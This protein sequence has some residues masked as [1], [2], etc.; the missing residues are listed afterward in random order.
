[1]TARR[2]SPRVLWYWLPAVLW[3]LAFR[4]AT[5]LALGGR[6]P[7]WAAGRDKLF[8]F[9]Y[10]GIMAFLFWRAFRFE[11]RFAPWTAAFAACLAA[12]VYGG[13][14]EFTQHFR[15]HRSA[16]F[17]DWLAD[18]AGASHVFLIAL[19]ETISRRGK[20][21]PVPEACPES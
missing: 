17:G 21:G 11:R 18:L 19:G 2:I 16:E 8:H 1:M 7:A 10:F 14:D 12:A 15:P 3:L 9:L 5:L 13:I 20:A 6:I 4:A